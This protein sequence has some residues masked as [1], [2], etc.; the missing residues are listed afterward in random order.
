MPGKG[1]QC[2]PAIHRGQQLRP[3]CLHTQIIQGDVLQAPTA[4]QLGRQAVTQI[5]VR[6]NPIVR[7]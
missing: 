3:G 7:I 4:R 5:F 6:H 2:R 1:Y